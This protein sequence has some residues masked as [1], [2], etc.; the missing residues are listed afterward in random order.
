MSIITYCTWPDVTNRIGAEGA[1]F[2]IDDDPATQA[3]VLQ[4]AAIEANGYLQPRY[5]PAT[6][7]QSN[8]VRFKVRDI[9]V[10]LLCLRR[11]MPPPASVEDRYKAALEAFARIE[12]GTSRVPDVYENKAS[13]PVLSNQRVTL[14]PF[15][16]VV[17]VTGKSTGTAEDYTQHTDTRDQTDYAG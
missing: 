4:S 5:E 16:R 12:A 9:A 1:E 14:T 2:R 7:A 8:W 15:P 10:Y 11:N 13:V 6:L 3:D 17:T